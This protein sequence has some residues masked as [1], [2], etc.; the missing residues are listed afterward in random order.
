LFGITT[1]KSTVDVTSDEWYYTRSSYYDDN[2][3]YTGMTHSERSIETKNCRYGYGYGYGYQNAPLTF[4]INAIFGMDFYIYKGLYMGA[5]LGLGYAF[6]TYLKGSYK[7][8]VTT[9]TTPYNGL[10]VKETDSKDEKFEDKM[11]SGNFGFRYNPMI[12]LGWR[13]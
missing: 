9:V 3:V 8:T 13:F 7:E 12:R 6:E 10:P 4:G 2:Y 11:T 1:S 5:E